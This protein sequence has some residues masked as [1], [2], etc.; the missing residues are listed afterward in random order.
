VNDPELGW[1][2]YGGNLKSAKDTLTV[3]PLD[4][5]RMRVYIASAGLWLTL[6]AGKFDSI[7]YNPTTH[8][9][10]VGLAKSSELTPQALLRIEQPAKVNGVGTYQPASTLKT[11]REGFVVPLKSSTTWVE[12]TAK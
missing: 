9:V 5:F 6:D 1:L 7:E 2:T 8:A 10:R 3:T 11:E 12:L 4:A